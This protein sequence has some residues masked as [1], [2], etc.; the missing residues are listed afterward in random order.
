MRFSAGGNEKRSL[1]NPHIFCQ[2]V[3]L[4]RKRSGVP[5]SQLLLLVLRWKSGPLGP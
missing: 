1:G 3:A 2:S 4:A 5:I